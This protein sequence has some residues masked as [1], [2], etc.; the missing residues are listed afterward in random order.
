MAC[1]R[2]AVRERIIGSRF[3][4][5]P[6]QLGQHQPDPAR[7]PAA[8]IAGPF[9]IYRGDNHRHHLTA[10]GKVVLWQLKR[11]AGWFGIFLP[12]DSSLPA[13]EYLTDK[14]LLPAEMSSI[15]AVQADTFFFVGENVVLIS[16]LGILSYL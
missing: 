8:G 6:L 13:A 9:A 12:D 7:F 5:L 11:I 1:G 10:P 15:K 3:I 4:D 2:S 16:D 14:H